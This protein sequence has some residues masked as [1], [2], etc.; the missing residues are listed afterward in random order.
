MVRGITCT[1]G[2]TVLVVIRG[3][4]LNLWW[5]WLSLG[6][7]TCGFKKAICVAS[8]YKDAECFI[9]HTATISKWPSLPC[10]WSCWLANFTRPTCASGNEFSN[11]HNLPILQAGIFSA[12]NGALPRIFQAAVFVWI[13][14]RTEC[15]LIG[16]IIMYSGLTDIAYTP[17]SNNFSIPYSGQ[18]YTPTV[19]SFQLYLVTHSGL[20]AV[21]FI[22]QTISAVLRTIFRTDRF[23]L[24]MSE[25]NSFLSATFRTDR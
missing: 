14:I 6:A 4:F 19:R 15:G 17:N 20:I 5:F 16:C 1:C 3:S 7:Y 11:C 22:R 21:H 13:T 9:Y 12:L 18:I 24:Q 8:T 25:E 10:P 23:P 2:V